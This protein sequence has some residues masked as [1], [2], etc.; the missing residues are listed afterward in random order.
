[1][2][3]RRVT[4]DV[5]GYRRIELDAELHLEPEIVSGHWGQP[6]L[7]LAVSRRLSSGVFEVTKLRVKIPRETVTRLLREI[8]KLHE[9]EHAQIAEDLAALK[10]TS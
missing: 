6:E 5:G 8:H 7:Q 3:T 2:A 9:R 10:V 1:M 4:Q